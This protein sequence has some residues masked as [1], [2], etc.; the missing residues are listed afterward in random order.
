M[1]SPTSP[2]EKILNNPGLVHLAENIFGNFDAE[3]LNVCK[4]INQS[5]IKGIS[6]QLLQI[7]TSN[8][9]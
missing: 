3:K 4:Q 5:D 9:F 6:L 1:A 2:M 7:H 8:K